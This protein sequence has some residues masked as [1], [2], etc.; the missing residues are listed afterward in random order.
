[1]KDV[2]HRS[3]HKFPGGNDLLY[4]L[5]PSMMVVRSKKLRDART[6]DSNL[7]GNSSRGF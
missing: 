5:R 2:A 1:M 6:G 7:G 4:C 3:S